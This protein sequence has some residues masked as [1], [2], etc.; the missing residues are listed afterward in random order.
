MAKRIPVIAA[1]W[2]MFKTKDEA[3]V[4]IFAVKVHITQMLLIYCLCTSNA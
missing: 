3:L 4:G 2:K 1:N